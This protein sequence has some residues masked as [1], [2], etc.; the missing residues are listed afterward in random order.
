MGCGVA[1]SVRVKVIWQFSPDFTVPLVAIK[2]AL[3]LYVPCFG[4]V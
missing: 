4:N 2:S 1:G 3:M